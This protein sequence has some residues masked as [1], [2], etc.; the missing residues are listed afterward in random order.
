LRMFIRRLAKEKGIS[1][2]ISSHILHEVQL[3]CDRVAIINQGTIVQTAAVQDMMQQETL[4][5]WELQPATDGRD[6][7][8]QLPYVSRV[9]LREPSKVIAQMPRDK[10]AEANAHLAGGDIQVSGIRAH[11]PTLEDIFLELTG[12]PAH[13]ET[14]L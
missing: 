4:V 9:E 3:M 6:R 11:Q 13:D 10:I 14:H 7:L 5:E 1:V 2:F 12:G 8:G